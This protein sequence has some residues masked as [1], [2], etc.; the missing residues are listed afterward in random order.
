MKT[1]PRIGARDI[2]INDGQ[3]IS[4]AELC[5][6]PFCENGPLDGATQMVGNENPSRPE[7]GDASICCFCSGLVCYVELDGKLKLRK[8]ESE[9]IDKYK[10]DSELWRALTELQSYLKIFIKEKQI[11]GNYLFF[12]NLKKEII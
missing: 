6:C 10:N 5:F 1:F 12:N 3:K 9:D 4:G 7:N 11:E 8:P 2:S